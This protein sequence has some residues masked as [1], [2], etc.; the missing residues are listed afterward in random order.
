VKFASKIVYSDGLDLAEPY[1]TPIGPACTICPRIRCPQ[2]A[3]AP[4][5]GP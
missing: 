4:A 1:V 5:D 2:R 3:A